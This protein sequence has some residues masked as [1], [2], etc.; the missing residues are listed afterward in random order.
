MKMTRVTLREL[1]ADGVRCR[2]DH[3]EERVA[4]GRVSPS[5]NG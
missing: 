5:L 4:A 2:Y 3:M 1:M